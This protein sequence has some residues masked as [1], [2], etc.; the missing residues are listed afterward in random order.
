M[1]T[2]SGLTVLALLAG[3]MT[4]GASPAT[5]L[6]VDGLGPA[7]IGM[8]VSQVEQALGQKLAIQYPEDD[9]CGQGEA[10][11]GP[12]GVS[13]MFVDGRLARVDVYQH[14]GGNSPS[15]KT[16]AGIGLGSSMAQVQRAYGPRLSIQPD[17]Y[18]DTEHYLVVKNAGPGREII[19]DTRM[20]RVGSFRA[21]L[22]KPVEYIEG[23][24]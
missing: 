16:D 13:Y 10:K 2:T 5:L 4:A 6:T 21:G 24:L 18:D 1:R 23:C 17:P 3:V 12:A 22:S 11:G 20:G 7:R 19:F 8:S 14:D 15:I 9:S